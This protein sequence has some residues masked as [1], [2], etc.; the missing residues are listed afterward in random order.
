MKNVS[1]LKIRKMTFFISIRDVK[2][3]IVNTNKY[4]IMIVYINDVIN[5]ITKT[6]YFT[7]KMHLINDFKINI[8]LETNIIT[9]QKITMN[10]KTRIVKLEKCQ[11]F[12]ISINIIARIQ[13]HFKRTIRNKFSIIIISN[14]IAKIF[15][16][17]NNIILENHDFLFE[18]NCFQ[19]FEF[20]N[21][22]LIHVVNFTILMILIY[23]ITII[24]VRL[25]RKARFETLFEYK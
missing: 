20:I 25:S 22:V 13:S 18:S 2:N 24:F 17:Y 7:M 4:V 1:E 9:P 11:R 12:Q 19:N 5:S 8:F 23:N 3:K 21:E 16:V 10:L 15:I 14:I 6:V